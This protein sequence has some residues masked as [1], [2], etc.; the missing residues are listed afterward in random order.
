[1]QKV[2]SIKT[3]REIVRQWR[4]QGERIAFVPT[5]GNL[6]AGHIRLVTEA[7]KKADRVVVS[8]FVNPTQFGI[9]EDF[10]NYPRTEFEDELKLKAVATDL[11]FFPSVNEIYQK[12]ATTVVSV[13]DLSKSY[14]GASRPGHF[15]GVATIVAKLFNMMQPDVAVFGEKDF[16]QLAVIRKVVQDLNI[17]VEIFGVVT[18]REPDG[19]AMSSRNGYLTKQERLIAPELYKSLCDARKIVMSKSHDLRTIEWQQKEHLEKLGFKVDYFSICKSNDLQQATDSDVELVIL[20]AAKL[21]KPRLIDNV[22][23]SR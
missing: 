19:L 11:L 6:H 23:F 1:M 20:V 15:D 10:E 21:G 4:Q 3:L 8:I 9:G 12:D 2:I 5:M 16:Q 14:C 13:G 18:E 17:P 7:R 22:Y